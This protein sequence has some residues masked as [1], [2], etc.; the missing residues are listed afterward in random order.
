MNRY[1]KLDYKK[2]IELECKMREKRKDEDSSYQV[3]DVVGRT[4][5]EAQDAKNSM[6]QKLRFDGSRNTSIFAA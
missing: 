4:V 5:K 2:R 3:R 6:K 1:F